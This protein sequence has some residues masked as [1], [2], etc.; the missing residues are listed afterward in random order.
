MSVTE[1]IYPDWVQKHCTQGT[2]VKKMGDA[3]YLY[4]RTSRRVPGK[5]YPQSIDTY[6]GIIKPDGVVRTQ[7]NKVTL[8][9]IE[10]WEYGYSKEIW[11]LCPQSWKDAVGDEWENV[12]KTLMLNWSP[13]TYLENGYIAKASKHSIVPLEHRQVCYRTV[14]TKSMGLI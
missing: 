5:K 12:L 6:I 11:E 9:N 7:K 13:Q 4:K 2:T 8:S 10:V 1:K 14:C 3:Y